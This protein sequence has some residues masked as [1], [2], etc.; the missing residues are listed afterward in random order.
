MN[1]EN[2]EL[3]IEVLRRVQRTLR[4]NHKENDRLLNLE[5][6]SQIDRAHYIGLKKGLQLGMNSIQFEID[7]ILEED[8]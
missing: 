7:G 4:R 6:C 5:G 3:F 2:A 1:E 8:K